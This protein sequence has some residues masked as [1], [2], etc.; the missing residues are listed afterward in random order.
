MGKWTTP[1]F[2]ATVVGTVLPPQMAKTKLWTSRPQQ[3]SE[4]GDQEVL[5]IAGLLHRGLSSGVSSAYPAIFPVSGPLVSFCAGT[6]T[7]CRL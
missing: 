3:R 7:G 6:P 4:I 2:S 1:N 5:P